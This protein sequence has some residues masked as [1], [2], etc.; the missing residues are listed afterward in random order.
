MIK[1]LR[2][3]ETQLLENLLSLPGFDVLTRCSANVHL[4]VFSGGQSSGVSFH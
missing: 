3:E 2:A 4:V 1:T